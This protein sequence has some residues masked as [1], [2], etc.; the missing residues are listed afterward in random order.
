MFFVTAFQMCVKI[1][2]YVVFQNYKQEYYKHVNVYGII[3]IKV[4]TR[5][6][7]IAIN[8]IIE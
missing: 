3:R 6:L 7:D 1:L 8:L 5:Y 4:E 2:C